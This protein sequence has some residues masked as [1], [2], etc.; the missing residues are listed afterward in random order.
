MAHPLPDTSAEY[1]VGQSAQ[2]NV[3]TGAGR[4]RPARSSEQPRHHFHD[5][6]INDLPNARTYV[7]L[8]VR[9]QDEVSSAHSDTFTVYSGESSFSLD[10]ES[11]GECGVTM[12]GSGL[13]W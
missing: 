9:G 2:E 7:K 12:S 13:A 1:G 6:R 3:D 5:P 8:P 10:D 11:D 4:V